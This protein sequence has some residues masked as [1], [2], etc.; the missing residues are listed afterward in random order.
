MRVIHFS[1]FTS[2]PFSS[3]SS[4]MAKKWVKVALSGHNFIVKGVLV[5]ERYLYLYTYFHL[6]FVDPEKE[7]I[8]SIQVLL[9][10]TIVD[11]M[12]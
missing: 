6:C 5:R 7:A 8:T 3:G 10:T 4:T 12:P 2:S 9:L 1:S 11:A